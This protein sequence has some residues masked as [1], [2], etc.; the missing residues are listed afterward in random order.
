MRGPDVDRQ[1]VRRRCRIT[2]E[3]VTGVRLL[4][5]CANSRAAAGRAFMLVDE[6]RSGTVGRRRL[7]PSAL[8]TLLASRRTTASIESSPL[9]DARPEGGKC[10]ANDGG[11]RLHASTGGVQ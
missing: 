8:S 6:R 10:P 9:A 4:L 5:R 2:P 11:P 3:A 7:V 1:S